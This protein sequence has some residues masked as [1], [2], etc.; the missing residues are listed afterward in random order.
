MTISD[1]QQSRLNKLYK[2]GLKFNGVSLVYEDINFHWTD[3]L[4][5]TDPEFDK[6]Y[7]GAVKRMAA[8]KLEELVERAKLEQAMSQYEHG[9]EVG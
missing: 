2:L 3:T 6:A 9:M 8:L 7:K 5:M 4:Y 1:Q